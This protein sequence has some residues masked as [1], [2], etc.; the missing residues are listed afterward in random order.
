MNSLTEYSNDPIAYR[1]LLETLTQ[2]ALHSVYKEYRRKL[3]PA[4]VR[5]LTADEVIAVMHSTLKQGSCF[6]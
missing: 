6:L 4:K 1:A 5:K 3:S 2:D